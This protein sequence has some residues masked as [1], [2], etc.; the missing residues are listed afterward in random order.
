MPRQVVS[1]AC[2]GGTDG[3]GTPVLP[4][5]RRAQWAAR[6]AIPRQ[7]G[8]ALIGETERGDAGARVG[9]RFTASGADGLPQLLGVLL[10]T[11]PGDGQR[12]DRGLDRC[13]D[14]AV[15]AKD[16]R[17]RRRG[18]LVDGEHPHGQGLFSRIALLRFQS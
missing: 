1:V 6:V 3:A 11:A 5:H 2:H 12:C 13:Q 8:L 15:I 17:L 16:D 4:R 9:D 10:D 14:L 7:H 18:S